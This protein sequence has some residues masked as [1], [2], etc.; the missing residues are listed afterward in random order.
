[1]FMEKLTVLKPYFQLLLYDLYEQRLEVIKVPNLFP[2]KESDGVS[3]KAVVNRNPEWY[4]LICQK[5]PRFRRS[6]KAKFVDTRV[7]RYRVIKYLN[8]LIEGKCPKALVIDDLIQAAEAMMDTYN[9]EDAEFFFEHGFWPEPFN[10][11]F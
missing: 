5:Y 11:Q 7:E 3:I 8:K 1:M 2:E 9:S 4:R 10:N 6:R